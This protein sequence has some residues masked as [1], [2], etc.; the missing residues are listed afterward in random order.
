[1][2]KRTE[3]MN[4]KDETP[5]WIWTVQ[6]FDDSEYEIKF[7]EASDWQC[8][9]FGGDSNSITWTPAKGEEPNWFW[10]KMQYLCFGNKWVKK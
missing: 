10:R 5:D 6:P 7:P 2:R 4:E 3:R 8:H 1:M 9:L